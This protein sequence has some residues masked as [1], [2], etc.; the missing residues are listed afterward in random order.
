MRPKKT[1]RRISNLGRLSFMPES[2]WRK[3]VPQK[4]APTDC[5][6]E[7]L[8]RLPLGAYGGLGL[9]SP[10]YLRRHDIIFAQFRQSVKPPFF[11]AAMRVRIS[12]S[13]W[14]P[15]LSTLRTMHGYLY[16]AGSV[17]FI[18][19]PLRAVKTM[20]AK[21]TKVVMR[22]NK[23][24]FSTFIPFTLSRVHSVALSDDTWSSLSVF[25]AY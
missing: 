8:V 3:L 11:L 13:V 19:I 21:T 20:L 7:N 2:W 5:M 10:L 17:L 4:K 22:T 14:H 1:K 15:R 23:L 12:I 16:G 25:S 18:C 6:A 24:N 9:V